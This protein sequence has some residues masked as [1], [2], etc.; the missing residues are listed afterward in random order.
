MSGNFTLENVALICEIAPR[1]SP[2][3]ATT[4]KRKTDHLCYTFKTMPLKTPG[5]KSSAK[6][7]GKVP[8]AAKAGKD[9]AAPAPKTSSSKGK[10]AAAPPKP[11]PVSVSW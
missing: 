7:V 4:E 3:R 5:P 2:T 10:K 8:P 6:T 1:H 9:K 11:E